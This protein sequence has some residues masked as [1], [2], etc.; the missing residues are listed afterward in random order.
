MFRFVIVTC[1]REYWES[2]PLFVLEK[3]NINK[4]E[5]TKHAPH[6]LFQMYDLDVHGK[7]SF[8]VNTATSIQKM[9]IYAAAYQL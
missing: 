6:K 4:T 3:N 9:N 1:K 2:A 7:D 8:K 5:M